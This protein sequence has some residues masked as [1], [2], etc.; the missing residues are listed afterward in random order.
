LAPNMDVPN[1]IMSLVSYVSI[2]IPTKRH[3][4]A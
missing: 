3:R 4:V 1:A 2:V